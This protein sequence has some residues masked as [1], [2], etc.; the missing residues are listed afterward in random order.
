MLRARV[1]LDH[2]GQA[3]DCDEKAFWNENDKDICGIGQA[4]AVLLATAPL[5]R[6]SCCVKAKAKGKACDHECCI[7]AHKEHNFVRNAR[8]TLTI[9]ATKQSS[10]KDCPH[11]CCKEAAKERK[12]LLRSV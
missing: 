6:Q 4:V 1:L 10:G 3:E 9:V 2:S 12:I 8:R 5:R 7:K 11:L